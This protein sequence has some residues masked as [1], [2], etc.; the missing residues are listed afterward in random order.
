V[1]GPINP[2]TGLLIDFQN[3]NSLVE[4]YVIDVLDHKDIT[5]YFDARGGMNTTVE[6]L[7]MWIYLTLVSNIPSN[8]PVKI[9]SVKLWETPTCFAECKG[10]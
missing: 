7:S 6:N 10:E 5:E 3:L 9:A 4:K 1:S 2:L 8:L